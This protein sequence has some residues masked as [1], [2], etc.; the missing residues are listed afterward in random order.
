M[1]TSNPKVQAFANRYVADLIIN[2]PPNE[3]DLLPRDFT[4]HDCV[5]VYR[6]LQGVR[7]RLLSE[8]ELLES[9]HAARPDDRARRTN[10]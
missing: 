3:L 1:P 6:V 8:A 7:E 2:A 10:S 9:L 5:A 4:S